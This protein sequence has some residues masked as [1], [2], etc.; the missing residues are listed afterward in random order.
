MR[1]RAI[2]S[3][4]DT[5][6]AWRL[7][8]LS[9]LAIAVSVGVFWIARHNAER[10]AETAQLSFDA[11]AA[12]RA[13]A[14]VAHAS[15]PAL[16]LAQSMLTETTV[17]NLLRQ[18]GAYPSDPA[19]GIGEFRSHLQ[20]QQPSG[21]LL[22]IV[23]HDSN[24]LTARKV[25][26]AVAAAIVNWRPAVAQSS[27]AAQQLTATSPAP[28]VP[29]YASSRTHD[30][31]LRAA[32]RAVANLE[33]QLAA[34][35]EKIENL[36]RVTASRVQ[37][38]SAPAPTPAQSDQRRTLQAKL[39]ADHQKLDELRLRYT[40]QYPDVEN[41]KDEI[42]DLQQQLAAFSPET[43]RP[44]RQNVTPV[45]AAEK[46]DTEIADLLQHR[47]RLLDRIAAQKD[48]IASIRL[49]PDAQSA[50][51]PPTT[52]SV[53][54]TIPAAASS[55]STITQTAAWE[56]PF[57]IARLAS[58]NGGS[59]AWPAVLASSLCVLLFAASALFI[60]R[61]WHHPMHSLHPAGIPL[62]DSSFT[63]DA[64]APTTE[65]PSP[66][67]P[68]AEEPAEH[69]VQEPGWEWPYEAVAAK[70]LCAIQPAEPEQQPMYSEETKQEIFDAEPIEA[71]LS[72]AHEISP[73]DIVSETELPSH[74]ESN[75]E[76]TDH[77]PFMLTAPD[78]P[79]SELHS[80]FAEM[81]MEAKTETEHELAS[82]PEWETKR[83]SWFVA[84]LESEP[85][86]SVEWRP[87]IS[88]QKDAQIALADSGEVDSEWIARTLRDLSQTSTVHMLELQ[89]QREKN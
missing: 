22:R 11:S 40:D 23:Y 51:A 8:V 62:E 45:A 42:S 32:D 58:L 80:E 14:A 77:E 30:S 17:L 46:D 64:H 56:N 65:L 9:V 82:A 34:T 25:A 21:S 70:D 67:A 43:T 10:S 71:S 47:A 20:L 88:K 84:G 38:A 48:A 74:E 41:L 60:F 18:A 28:S 35:N 79:W 39:A 81:E 53:P 5:T 7:G 37:T 68:V 19:V 16:T 78:I 55:A 73:A 59:L 86:A 3:L 6:A 26:N 1:I 4:S 57:K 31:T 29:A 89:R 75:S 15:E 49:H 72:E 44:S 69:F 33:R 66:P 13:D 83:M 36:N 87:S 50:S 76:A 61:P 24:P 63:Y 27:A 52:A 85:E 12:A 2:S 54:Q